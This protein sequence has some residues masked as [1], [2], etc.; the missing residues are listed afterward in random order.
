MFYC[1]STAANLDVTVVDAD[2]AKVR[3][4]ED[5]VSHTGSV[6]C[7][8][9]YNNSLEWDGKDDAGKVVADGAYTVRLH[10][11]D[12]AGQTGDA[13]NRLGVDTRSPGALTSPAPGDTVSGSVKWVFTPTAGFRLDSVSIN[14]HSG[15]SGD[16]SNAAAGDGTFT[17][18]MD[19][20]NCTGG[21]NKLDAWASWHDPLGQSHSWSA[22]AVTVMVGNPPRVSVP[23]FSE[24]YFSPNGD[25]Q[26]DTTRVFYCL[27]TAANLDVTVV[28]ADG[29]KVRTLEDGVSHTGSVNCDGSYNNS[30]EWDGKD[31]AGKV[32]ADGAYTVRLHAVDAAG[33][34]EDAT[35][36]LGVDTRSPGALTSPAP[37]DTV[38]GSVKWVF[39]PTAGFRL[40]SVSINCHS[41]SSGDTSNAAAGDGTF[42]GSMD[43]ANCTGGANKLDAWASWHDPLGQSHSWSAPAVTVMVGNPPR[44]SVPS[45]SERY[46]SP[47]GDSQEDTTRVFYCLSTAANLDVT[48]VDADGAKVR[49]LEDGVSH[50]GSVNCDGSYNNSLEWD[51]KDDAGKVVADGAYTVRL[52]AV[53]AAGQTEDATNRLGVDTR[54]PGALTSPAPGDTVSGS[55]KW[56]F[57][58]TAGFRLDSVSINCH[59]GSSG[60]TS[61]AAAGDGT[62]TGSWTPPTAPAGPTSSMPGR[63]GMTRWARAIPGRRRR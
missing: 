32:V 6:N 22:P 53:D 46:F 29:A 38:S 18:S 39:T 49:T 9:S 47:N 58:P 37:G 21:A 42:T 45:F 41:G 40:D 2:G 23:S 15:S 59:S 25:S 60:D 16:T 33:Q 5:G 11:V 17:G 36:R 14:C 61:N 28:D 8:G 63:P 35:N 44:V 10:A 30:L 4:L 52:H 27:S 55:V 1:L 26:E 19:T 56:V 12:A 20:A 50:T 24:R 48:V 51:G 43:T 34:T 54:S 7:D 57:T 62:F 3:T 31:D 13:T